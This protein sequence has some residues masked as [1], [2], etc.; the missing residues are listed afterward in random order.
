MKTSILTLIVLMFNMNSNAQ[1]ILKLKNCKNCKGVI[2]PSET[3][4]T[5]SLGD[6]ENKFTPSK[7]QIIIAECLLANKIPDYT[8]KYKRYN[9]QFLGIHNLRGENIILVNLLNFKNS[10]SH[11][12]NSFFDWGKEWVV[13]FGKFYEKNTIYYSVNLNILKIE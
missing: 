13:G 2:L 8:K 6:Y 3:K 9:R 4:L 12:E 1:E 5:V 7:D 11:I 10:K